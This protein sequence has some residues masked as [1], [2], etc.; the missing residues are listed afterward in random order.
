[1]C[2]HTPTHIHVYTRSRLRPGGGWHARHLVRQSSEL[3]GAPLQGAGSLELQ[4]YM[5]TCACTRMPTHARMHAH[6]RDG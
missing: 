3:P 6:T 2:L 5:H 4:T 1:M